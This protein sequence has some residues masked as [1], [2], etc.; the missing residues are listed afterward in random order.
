MRHWQD[1]QAA[2]SCASFTDRRGWRERFIFE[3]ALDVQ[4]GMESRT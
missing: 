2:E 4:F 3:L 1:R